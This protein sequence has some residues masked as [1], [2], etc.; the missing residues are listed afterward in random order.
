MEE[1][2]CLGISKG[3]R[4]GNVSAHA[5][6]VNGTFDSSAMTSG[7]SYNKSE[8]SFSCPVGESLTSCAC[9]SIYCEGAFVDTLTGG[10][11]ARTSNLSWPLYVTG[12][13]MSFDKPN[14][15]YAN[16]TFSSKYGGSTYATCNGGADYMTGC[17]CISN[18]GCNGTF[19]GD[20][21]T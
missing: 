14:N 16:E 18:Y 4:N 7:P 21:R 12:I 19:I 6:C 10:C 3:G 1:P 11:V 17:S 15:T 20:G 5:R 9:D 2:E 8:V 13:C